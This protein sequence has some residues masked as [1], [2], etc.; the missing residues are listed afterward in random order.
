[1]KLQHL[2]SVFCAWTASTR[3]LAPAN[4]YGWDDRQPDNSPTGRLY[5]KGRPD[6]HVYI[7]DQHQHPVVR[8]ND[9]WYV[10]AT[11]ET[12]NTSLSGKRQLFHPTEYRVSPDSIPP[13]HLQGDGLLSPE[14]KQKNN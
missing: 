5:L 8:D 2:V 3:A 10:Y 14:R 6:T 11:T 1:M 4:P 13:R 7:V 12:N 9:G